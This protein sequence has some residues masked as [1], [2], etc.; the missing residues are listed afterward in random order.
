MSAGSSQ[1]SG[2]NRLYDIPSLENDGTNFQTW[3]YWIS[4]VLRLRGLIGIVDGTIKRPI[5][6]QLANKSTNQ[7]DINDWDRCDM[8]AQAQLTLTLKD[9]PLSGVLHVTSAA[10]VWDKLN[11]CYEGK[12]Q[13]TITYLIKEIFCA[14]FSDEMPME[15]Q[16]NDVRHKAHILKTVTN[17]IR[18][19]LHE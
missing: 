9:E 12:G 1:I 19:Y 4:T 8:E 6:A 15:P 16:L 11:R 10:D 14:L 2:S 3:K 17:F 5:L 7:S 18:T 13:N